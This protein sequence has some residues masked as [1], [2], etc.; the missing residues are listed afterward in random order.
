[1][2]F[3]YLERMKHTGFI[4]VY[5]CPTRL[6]IVNEL[7]IEFEDFDPLASDAD[8]VILAGDIGVGLEGL[9][10]AEE[11]FPDRSVIYEPGNHEFY[12]HDLSLT[13]ELTSA[14]ARAKS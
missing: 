7:P 13:D 8:V 4:P 3:D 10:W 14:G 1:M 11:P 9:R 12:R 2:R 6:H 5:G